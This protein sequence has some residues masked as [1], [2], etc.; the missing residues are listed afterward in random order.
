MKD[1]IPLQLNTDLIVTN[2]AGGNM[3]YVVG[4]L[5]AMGGSCLVYDGY[6]INNAGTK[7]TVRIKECYPYKLNIKRDKDMS[8]VADD[9]DE[10]KFLQYKNRIRKAFEVANELHQMSGITNLTSNVFDIYD[11]NN[12]IYI[13]SSYTEGNTLVNAEFESLSGVI[14]TMI[15]IAKSIEKIHDRGFLYLDIKPENILV[16]DETTDLIQLFDFDSL[17]HFE[18]CERISEYRIS[19]TQGFAPIEQKSGNIKRL[20]WYTDVY[21]LGALFFYLLF[22]RVPKACDCG[23]DVSYSFDKMKWD[24]LYQEKVY[25]ELTVFFHNTLQAYYKDRYQTV[26][27]V[28]RQLEIICKYAD[29]PVPFICTGY[30]TNGGNVVG[31]ECE[32]KKIEK[33]CEGNE[34]L[35]FVTG[36]GGIGKS[37]IVRKFVSENKEKYDNLIFL[38]FRESIVESI[39]DDIQFCINGYEKKEEESG[40]EYFYRKLKVAKELTEGTNSILIIDNFDGIIDDDFNEILKINWKVIV[41]T[42]KDMS[43]LGCDCIK[44]DALKD[45]RE[46]HRLFEI[47]LNRKLEPKEC[48]KVDEIVELVAGHTL[49]MVLIARQISKSFIDIDSALKL[50]TTNG[51]ADIAP[52][53][54]GYM[55]DGNEYYDKISAIIKA[56]YDVTALSDVKKKCLKILSIFDINGIN[57]KDSK[58]LIKLESLDEINELVDLGWLELHGEYVCMHPL[59]QETLHQMPWTDEYRSIVLEK[60]DFL[61]G[62]FETFQEYISFRTTLSTSKTVLKNCGKDS[63]LSNE[64]LY[65][66]LLFTTIIN[67]PKD[68]EDYVIDNCEMLLYDICFD[69]I[70]NIIELYDYAIYLL[71]QKCDYD[72]AL[73]YLNR[74]KLF[75]QKCKDN[76]I[77]GLYYDM[78]GDYYD[79]ML[80]G[81]YYS[82]NKED[83]ELLN[84]MLITIDNAIYH[85]GKSK[86]KKAVQ[87]YG[88][89]VLGKASLMI[90]SVPE[91]CR[92]IKNLILSTKNIVEQDIF[93]NSELDFIYHLTWAW[94]YT[95]CEPN[96]DEVWDNLQEA[97]RI[98]GVR[99]ISELDEIDYFYIPAANMMIELGDSNS[100]LGLLDEACRICNEHMEEIPY[101][102]KKND[103]LEYK[104]Q[105]GTR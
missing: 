70:Y 57:I 11:T 14:R 82:D 6:Y 35:L 10:S 19:Y 37:T 76:Y 20:G 62:E 85:M 75:A 60:M 56:V 42:R 86:H 69:K 36:M 74:A 91:K 68:Q 59:I 63:K 24:T 15:S 77:W 41:V 98:N 55:Q 8:L 2:H 103:L 78:L 45:K 32:Y 16:Y 61:I 12:T 104:R 1:R 65:K 54:V 84:N 87:L 40:S 25:K 100:S 93:V 89:Y 67:S 49:A 72:K 9:K 5:I 21:S 29:L 43:S 28:I 26:S 13:V 94:F 102:R 97:A 92:K 30:V 17:V 58:E 31:R 79:C 48:G 27:E 105:V 18:E 34:K 33:W 52:E 73:E 44:I 47:Y 83:I 88:K 39:T 80:D 81:A 38:K 95:L 22:G 64:G 46:Q 71:C 66:D 23:F 90:R 7:N 50:V 4:D 101:I 99:N 51:L 53:K 3:H 96:M